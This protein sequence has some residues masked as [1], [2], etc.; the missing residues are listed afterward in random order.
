MANSINER[1]LAEAGEAALQDCEL[2]EDVRGS[3]PY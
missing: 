2:I 3:I 1:L